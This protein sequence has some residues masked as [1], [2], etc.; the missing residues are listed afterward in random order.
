VVLEGLLETSYIVAGLG[1]LLW[2]LS[3]GVKT[4]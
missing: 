1:A 3:I 2:W 4:P